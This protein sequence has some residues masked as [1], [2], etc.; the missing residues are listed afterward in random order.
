MATDEEE[1][2][3]MTFPNL[4]CGASPCGGRDDDESSVDIYDGLDSAPVL[5]GSPATTLTPLKSGLNLFDE[6][7]IEEGTAK[8]ASYH[9]LQAEHKICKQQLQE[10]MKKL[11]E[12]QEQNS[13]LQNENQSLKKNISAL[14][15]TARVEINRKDEEISNL[16]RRLSEV[17]VHPN[18]Y[19]RTYFQKSANNARNFEG[20]KAKNN[21]F[22]DLLPVNN[23][24]MD[25]RTKPSEPKDMPHSYTSWDT[26]NKKSHSEK[27]NMNIPRSHSEDPHNSGA[28]SRLTNVDSSSDKEKGK[29]EIKSNEHHN[30]END[31]KYK[32]KTHQNGGSTADGML[33]LHGKLQLNSEK[34]VGN[35]LWKDNNDTKIKSSPCADKRTDTFPCAWE[36]PLTPKDTLLPKMEHSGDDKSEKSQNASQ[37]D[38]K[39]QNKDESNGRQKTRQPEKHLEQ[40]KRTSKVSS[41]PENYSNARSPQ[42]LSKSYVEDRKIKD[43]DCRRNKEA[44]D[45]GLRGWRLSPLSA[46]ISNK[47]H[48]H[49]RSKDDSS[50]R[51]SERTH[52]KSERHRTEE[53][54][55]NERDSLRESRSFQ[56]ERTDSKEMSQK[57]AK[58]TIKA[59][60]SVKKEENKSLP[61]EETV[62][63]VNDLE[64]QLPTRL[65]RNEEQST[66]KALK[67]SF[68]Q[69]LNLTLS[70]A[71]KQTDELKTVAKSSSERDIKIPGQEVMFVPVET[72]GTDVV[73]QAKMPPL[74]I[75]DNPV[76]TSLGQKMSVSKTK[77]KVESESVAESFNKQPP[78]TSSDLQNTAQHELAD[79]AKPLPEASI[80]MGEADEARVALSL[81]SPL[82][83]DMLPDNAFNDVETISSVDFDSYSVIDEINGSDSDSLMEVEE[84]SNCARE[85]VLESPK[86]ESQ[87]LRPVPCKDT[88]GDG[89]ILSGDV[90][91]TDH[92]ACN[93]KPSFPDQGTNLEAL[94][95]KG[96][97]ATPQTRDANPVSVDDENSILSIDLNHMR[98]IPKAISPLNSP[99][100]P[101]TKALRMESL[102]KGPVKS[103]NTDL[104]PEDAVVCPARNLSND[105]NKENQKP[106]CTDRQL[107]EME[108]QQSLSSDELEEG[109]IVSDDDQPKTERQENCKKS[110]GKASPDQPNL[111]HS[112]CNHKAKTIPSSEGTGKLASRGKSKEKPK[113]G[114]I[115]SSKEVK[116]NKTVS[117]DCLE[118][119]VQ[120]TAAP[121]TV[122]EFMQML[123]A[124]RKQVR[125]NYMKFKMQFPVKH[126]HRIVDTAILNFISLVKYLD[127]SKMSKTSEALKRNLCE[128]I[129]TKLK[130]IKKNSA[131]EHLF[132]QQQS[133]MKK[134]LW[135]LVD[136]QLDYLFE[137]IKKILLKLCNLIS[138]GNESDEGRLDKRTKE[139]PRCLAS[140][141]TER[142]KSKKPALNARTQKPEKC[143][144]PKSVASNQLPKNGHHD[145][146]KMDAHKNMAKKL[147]SPYTVKTKHSQTGV[148][149]FKEKSIQDRESA[150]KN[151]KCAK[152]GS[153]I[154]GDK[155]DISCGPLTEQQM[156]GLTFNL[157]NDAQ[158]GEMF[159]SLLQGSGL[160]EK[161][162]DFV[163][164]SQWEFK[165]PEKHMPDGQNCGNDSVYE[166]ESTPKETQIESRVLDGIKWPLVSPERDSSFLARLQMPIDPDILDESCM[167]EIP[168]SPALKKGEVC[169]SGKPKS[170]VS[171]ILLEDL[172][173]SLTIPSPL[174]SDAHL[175][176][177]KP[178]MFGTVPEDVLSAHFSED[179]HLE[180]EDASEQ[181]I[182]LALESDNSSSKSSCSS[183]WASMPAAPGF[184]Y[185]P[186][187][188]M[189]AVVMEKSNDHFIVKIRRA[190]PS[191]SP[192]LDQVSLAN[193]P[194]TSFAE[195]GDN[196]IMPEENLDALNFQ[197]VPLEETVSMEKRTDSL[198][199]THDNI[200]KDKAPDSLASTKEPSICLDK[201]KEA[202]QSDP[203]QETNPAA[204]DNVLD[205]VEALFSNA[206]QEQLSNMAE[207]LQAPYNNTS[208]SQGPD[209]LGP[210]QVS[211]GVAGSNGASDW[212]DPPREWGKPLESLK[213]PSNKTSQSEDAPEVLKLP[214]THTVKMF[215]K[216]GVSCTAV[217]HSP[218]SSAVPLEEEFSSEGHFDIC[219]DLTDETPL[220]NEVDSWDLTEGSTLN[221]GM[222]SLNK[223]KEGC[224]TEGCSVAGDPLTEE[225][226][227]K[228][229][230]D[231][232]FETETTSNIDISG[233]RPTLDKESKKRKKE[234]TEKSRAKRE[235]KE[236]CESSCKKTGKS[237]KKSKE[238]ASVAVNASMKKSA[239]VCDASP[240]P[241]TSSVSPS[242]LYAKNVIKKK[243]EVVISWTRNDDREILLE[244]QKKGPSGK[245]F[246]SLAAKLNKSSNQVEER[247]K[248]LVKLFKMSSCN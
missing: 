98:Y 18:T 114:T 42:T 136:E 99:I 184:Q 113:A 117:I 51:E 162:V 73:K 135:K 75:P 126:F 222:G 176:F 133:D 172:A 182:H 166:A 19:T 191:T 147:I 46:L 144:L 246:A 142:Q 56:N 179:A 168:S 30:T 206:K 70:P 36:K 219:I 209:L 13:A 124:V 227:G 54:R 159:K 7:L 240:L 5:S 81:G 66:T 112:P 10:L 141:K 165:T 61:P 29:K 226:P 241:S 228:P 153:Q 119:I 180:E 100:R 4:L 244:C 95:I 85:K 38:L 248:Q 39:I 245:T 171:S 238:T 122:H 58:D 225:Q 181:D 197:G 173:V 83:Q 170:L 145:T 116:K 200:G 33:D 45:L 94:C 167:F 131:I 84:T 80:E 76:Q 128:V 158:M 196:E 104:V 155:T 53:K 63:V 21:T 87:R 65:K 11:Q 12:I 24:K 236:S 8:E 129:E 161:N 96:L 86:K 79:N 216:G 74:P 92:K 233:C 137:K 15:K 91:L 107:L 140:H 49:G 125:K 22:K 50:K 32:T 190:T 77:V 150:L 203:Q 187:L 26:E 193:E 52:S 217:E 25:S 35:G 60:V 213:E 102:Y 44:S 27:R 214:Q 97:S 103:Y 132:K 16:Q 239:S 205:S 149:L 48:K 160:S 68:M 186:S 151:G 88:I 192:G 232:N 204:P 148:E 67:L 143:D 230:A 183:T 28:H 212:L 154:V 118:K 177:L 188:P 199:E 235:R 134:K 110:R 185:C 237:N 109:E 57:T 121:S 47:D 231:E 201:D 218:T 221:A 163:D 130:Q 34:T 223:D 89:N 41:S 146:N 59:R 37:K 210:H 123:R 3:G 82:N 115:M 164:E 157:V 55:K 105:L 242:S 71:K 207:S 14:I 23:P 220:E 234:T 202:E 243:G 247:F 120:I 194:V 40:Q 6:I 215:P 139:S 17:P 178:D 78:K 2:E 90:P 9:D 69:K 1:E 189:Q 138:I 43:S 195:R 152:E 169:I 175:S 101:L 62:K 72:I 198:N 229:T 106:L 108:S 31:C 211:H 156:S 20:S 224:K 174:K 127:F 208:H 111:A 64:E 93:G